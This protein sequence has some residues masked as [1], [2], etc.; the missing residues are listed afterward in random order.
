MKI[1]PE[2]GYLPANANPAGKT[3]N[4]NHPLLGNFSLTFSPSGRVNFGLTKFVEIAKALL[5]TRRGIFLKSYKAVKPYLD[6]DWLNLLRETFGDRIFVNWLL[7][8]TLGL[9]EPDEVLIREFEPEKLAGEFFDGDSLEFY[10]RAVGFGYR[11]K[12]FEDEEGKLTLREGDKLYAL[13][14]RENEY[15]PNAVALYHQNGER[16]G[17]LRKSYAPYLK[18]KLKELI[19]LE[20]EIIALL[21]DGGPNETVFVR[22]LI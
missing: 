3:L 4:F 18:E 1:T 8:A 7:E 20:G 12:L 6:H 17:Y 13:W 9:F 15:D 14:E 2:G 5:Y 19:V 16:L 21:P 10:T 11:R 22:L